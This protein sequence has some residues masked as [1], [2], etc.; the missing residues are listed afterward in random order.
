MLVLWLKADSN[1]GAQ[2]LRFNATIAASSR[3]AGNR[4]NAQNHN[5]PLG[6][7]DFL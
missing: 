4:F 5:S 1:P 3:L 7:C 2:P 6:E